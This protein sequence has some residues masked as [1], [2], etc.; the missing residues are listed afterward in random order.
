MSNVTI[1]T[2][3]SGISTTLSFSVTGESGKIGFGNV[4]IPKSLV[5]SG[6]IVTITNQG[7]LTL[8]H[9]F[10]ED[11]NNYYVWYTTHFS[12]HEISIAFTT[13][14]YSPSPSV[15]PIQTQ[16]S[17]FHEKIF[18]LVVAVAILVNISVMLLLRKVR[19]NQQ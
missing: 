6:A 14:T 17:L 13:T 9:G 7:Q 10:V 16:S 11:S 15:S 4:T 3:Q 8:D 1:A 18:G 12:T 19:R 2:G 5:P